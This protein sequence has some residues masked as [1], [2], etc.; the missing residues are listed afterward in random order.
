[1]VLEERPKA[2]ALTAPE[3]LPSNICFTM[4]TFRSKSAFIYPTFFLPALE[5]E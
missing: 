2:F 3:I 1:M 4:A 5:I